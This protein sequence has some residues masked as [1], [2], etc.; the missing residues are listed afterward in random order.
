MHN[1]FID[2]ETRKSDECPD[3]IIEAPK[4]YSNP[5]TIA[6]YIAN[7]RAEMWG[8]TALDEMHGEICSIAWAFD[9]ME[10]LAVS[11]ENEEAL[12][13]HFWKYAREYFK[14]NRTGE[15]LKSKVQWV[16][17]NGIEFDIP[18]LWIR[19][20]KYGIDLK[21]VMPDK[22]DV[23]D[24]MK[25]WNPY[26]WKVYYKQSD[27]IEALGGDKSYE[28][29]SMVQGWYDAGDLRKIMDYNKKDI[30]ELRTIYNKLQ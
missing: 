24:T 2:I 18:W 16:T 13:R 29:G 3:Y 26:K 9:D 11:G 12:I 22:R 4:N 27:I 25:K 30:E 1:L 10:P 15:V 17:H 19:C 5:K 23:Y 8:K 7:K 20:V 6:N 21:K 28:D 14:D